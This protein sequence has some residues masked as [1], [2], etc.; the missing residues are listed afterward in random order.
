MHPPAF[1]T[2]CSE[3]IVKFVPKNQF[4]IT[5]EGKVIVKVKYPTIPSILA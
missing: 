5:G 2:K 3:L 1:D 4:I